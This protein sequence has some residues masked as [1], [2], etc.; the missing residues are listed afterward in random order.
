MVAP[1]PRGENLSELFAT[2]QAL[3]GQAPG[4]EDLI[5][6]LL[7][8]RPLWMR[9]ALCAESHPGVTFFSERGEDVEAA[10]RICSRC[11]VLAECRSWAMEQ[12]AEL[13]GV[14]AGTTAGQRQQLRK[15]DPRPP[16]PPRHRV[17]RG[18]A[19]RASRGPRRQP[20][21]KMAAASAFL[22]AHPDQEHAA[23]AVAAA[24]TGDSRAVDRAL[25]LL[26]EEGYATVHVG[27]I[28]PDG[29][30][31]PRARYYRHVRPY[32]EAEERSTTAA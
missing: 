30:R 8:S 13:H 6:A 11:L 15:A 22:A 27:G 32:L 4:L 29:H 14:W 26:V 1:A 24:V 17:E 2:A 28:G 18:P 16:R 21:K 9:D 3:D 25:A 23:R 5:G 19:E 7:A 31:H 12:G 20:A 10:K